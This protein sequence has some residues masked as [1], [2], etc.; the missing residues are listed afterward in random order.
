MGD[1]GEKL[2]EFD[3]VVEDGSDMC[4][5]QRYFFEGKVDNS[6]NVMYS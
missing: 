6:F 4:P 1:D 3:V 2:R 5:F